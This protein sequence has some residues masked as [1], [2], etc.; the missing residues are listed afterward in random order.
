MRRAL[1]PP[2]NGFGV[3]AWL[4]GVIHGLPPLSFISDR[5]MNVA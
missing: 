4:G 1:I 2:F 5:Q 3:V